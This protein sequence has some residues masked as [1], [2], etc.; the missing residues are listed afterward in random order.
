MRDIRAA[1]LRQ[2]IS[3][4]GA[5]AALDAEGATFDSLARSMMEI[6]LG[7]VPA[8][9]INLGLIDHCTGRGS[10]FAIRGFFMPEDR[11]ELLPRYVDQH[12]MLAHAKKTGEGPPM[13]FTD[14]MSRSDFER[15]ELYNECYR[16]C[17]HGMMTFKLPSPR[18]I[19]CSFVLSRNDRDFS[20]RDR[21][22]LAALQPQ[23][24]V[25]YRAAVVR[26][27]SVARTATGFTDPTECGVIIT[28]E[29]GSIRTINHEAY[30]LLDTYAGRDFSA[31]RLPGSVCEYL[32][33]LKDRGR[34]SYQPIEFSLPTQKESLIL[35]PARL[36]EGWRSWPRFPGQILCPC[37]GITD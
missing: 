10:Y 18:N 21:Q 28:T 29:D 37:F 7:L 2:V 22:V 30:T 1:D 23:L 6:I 12:P 35:R 9:T 8:D 24:A 27:E 4:L 5:L 32:D 19:N 26:A 13:Q 36:P 17:T 14:F 25:L 16:G 15:T 20:E 34:A 31:H 3:G 33:S 11:R